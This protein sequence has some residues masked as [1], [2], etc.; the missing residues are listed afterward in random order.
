VKFRPPIKGEAQCRIGIDVEE[1]AQLRG[2]RAQ[3]TDRGIGRIDVGQAKA[4]GDQA[5]LSARS[6]SQPGSTLSAQVS[7]FEPRA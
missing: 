3:P 1:A 4:G 7:S 2:K 5:A 6:R